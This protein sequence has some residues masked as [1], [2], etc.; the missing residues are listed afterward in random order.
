MK[1]TRFIFCMSVRACPGLFLNTIRLSLRL[2]FFTNIISL[3]KSCLNL[4]FLD[5]QINTIEV[6][7]YCLQFNWFNNLALDSNQLTTLRF[8][9]SKVKT[10]HIGRNLRVKPL[11]HAS[12]FNQFIFAKRFSRHMY[13]NT[14]FIPNIISLCFYILHPPPNILKI[15]R[16]AHWLH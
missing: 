8:Q 3:L 14:W 16:K 10:C 12:Y 5:Y 13:F 4:S 1:P 6:I 7:T 9:K 2:R 15:T 11:K